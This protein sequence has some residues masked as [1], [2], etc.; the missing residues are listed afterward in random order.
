M[1][2]VNNRAFLSGRHALP[3]GYPPFGAITPRYSGRF[4]YG[5]KPLLMRGKPLMRVARPRLI[6]HLLDAHRA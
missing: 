2:I 3:F 6:K 4:F 1:K 5:D